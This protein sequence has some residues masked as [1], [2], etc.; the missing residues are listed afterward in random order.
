MNKKISLLVNVGIQAFIG[1]AL[2]CH[3]NPA[4]HSCSLIC[5]LACIQMY[6]IYCSNDENK[7]PKRPLGNVR[8]K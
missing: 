8:T 3:T 4:H 7:K 2:M 5:A 1:I 6:M